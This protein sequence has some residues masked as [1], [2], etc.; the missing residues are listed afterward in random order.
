VDWRK[1]EFEI[2]KFAYHESEV[3][4]QRSDL[5][6]IENRVAMIGCMLKA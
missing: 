2:K 3:A 6:L 5:N 1:N 4:F